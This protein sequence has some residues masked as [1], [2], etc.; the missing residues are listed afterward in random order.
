MALS[1]LNTNFVYGSYTADRDNFLIATENQTARAGIVDDGKQIPTIGI[2]FN[3]SGSNFSWS[4]TSA[5]LTYALGGGHAAE[6]S[7]LQAWRLHTLVD[8]A[9]YTFIDF[10]DGKHA[11]NTLNND[12]ILLM[13][14]EKVDGERLSVAQQLL[15]GFTLSAPQQK[16]LLD[17]L[18]DGTPTPISG[19]TPYETLL[20]NKL[21][22]LGAGTVA[23]SEERVSFVAR[24]RITG[25]RSCS[26]AI[27]ALAL[28]VRMAK[29]RTR[30][31]SGAL[32]HS[33]TPAKASGVPSRRA[34]A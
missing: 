11:G 26:V 19:F 15:S 29:V 1:S 25:M 4:T 7:I 22:K 28:V 2:G 24:S 21:T 16:T 6:L 8:P 20:T 27:V 34:M 17:G 30:V 12:D 5:L 23:P 3:I 10:T 33:H 18:L 31:L 13:A 9:A 32:H 14:G